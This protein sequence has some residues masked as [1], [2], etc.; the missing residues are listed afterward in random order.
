MPPVSHTG[1]QCKELKLLVVVPDAASTPTGIHTATSI[2]IL[3]AYRKI[4]IYRRY[5][6]TLST[7]HYV[8]IGVYNK[9]ISSRSYILLF[10]GF[11]SYY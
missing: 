3:N 9:N 8:G 6:T 7:S 5:C 10:H 1:Q 11:A 4:G 2:I